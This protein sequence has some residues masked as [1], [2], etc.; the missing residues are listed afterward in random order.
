MIQRLVQRCT[1]IKEQ[2]SVS[3]GIDEGEA[4]DVN[5]EPESGHEY[6]VENVQNNFKEAYSGT[7]RRCLGLRRDNLKTE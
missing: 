4:G 3:T 7:A 1:G 2:I 6:L 5:H